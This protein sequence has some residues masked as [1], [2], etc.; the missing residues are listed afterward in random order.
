MVVVVCGE[1]DEGML[2]SSQTWYSTKNTHRR[3]HQDGA[4]CT[5][6][7]RATEISSYYLAGTNVFLDLELKTRRNAEKVLGQNNAPH[8]APTWARQQGQGTS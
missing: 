5:I 6:P 4:L 8:E 2:V 7:L 3:C 1:N